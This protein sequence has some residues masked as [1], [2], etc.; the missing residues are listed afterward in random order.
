MINK[1]SCE[2]LVFN[3]S[4]GFFAASVVTPGQEV[5]DRFGGD[6][7]GDWWRFQSGADGAEN[8]CP[9]NGFSDFHSEKSR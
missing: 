6:A 1:P 3:V 9:T 7:G 5:K 4:T 2:L 8:G